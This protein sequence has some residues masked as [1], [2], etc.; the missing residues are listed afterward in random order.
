[1][2]LVVLGLSHH[3][4][5]LHLREKFDFS[6]VPHEAYLSK[7][8]NF[9]SIRSGMVLSTCN[10]V[11][12]YASGVGEKD[13]LSDTEMFLQDF[14][15]LESGEVRPHL[16]SRVN[17]DAVRHL[18]RVAAS[19]DSLVV[20]E[21]QILG[22]VKEA[23]F[24]AASASLTDPFFDK[25]L[26]RTFSVAKKIRT[27]TRIAEHAVSVSYAAVELAEKI[28]GELKDKQVM[29]LGAGEMAELAARHLKGLGVEGMYFVNRSYDHSVELAKEFGGNPIQ[30]VQ[31]ERFLPKVDIVIVSTAAPHYLVKYEQV[32]R[33]MAERK[34]APVFIIDISV[35]R[36]VDPKVHDLENVYLYNIDDLEGIVS[37]NRSARI[38]EAEKAEAIVEAE[39][40]RFY[41]TIG[42]MTMAPV[43][44]RLQEKYEAVRRAE[45][46]RVAKKL[47]T[48]SPEQRDEIDRATN[49]LV[50]KI[51]NDPILFMSD[52]H[53]RKDA[54]DRISMFLRIFGIGDEESQ[55]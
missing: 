24:D 15:R 55:E 3:T 41:E 7:L 8:A 52:Q 45:I 31:F 32:E 30:L 12:V 19:L 2:D 40:E 43:I 20:G 5:P 23:Y 27:E 16:Y 21:P 13:L 53:S 54:M 9:S 33:V 29:I 36:N 14:H 34:Q 38:V 10:R 50:K 35:P 51:L 47:P 44:Q 26:Q 48:L 39:V 37:E 49:S 46:D 28:F 25:L 4:A 18:F 1:M 11:E 22:Q 6:K 42:K 17:R